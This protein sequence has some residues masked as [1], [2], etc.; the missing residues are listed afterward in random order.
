MSYD[1]RDHYYKEAK[2]KGFRAR[3]AFK[4]EQ[5]Q[6]K[7]YII[8]RKDIVIDLGA[9]PGGWTQ[10]ASK[11]VGKQGKVIAVDINHIK[12]FEND[13][14]YTLQVDMMS[15]QFQNLLKEIIEPPIDVVI[16]DLAGNTSGN[17]DLDSERQ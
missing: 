14:I 4:L 15:K 16:S 5:I 3:S 10:V 7:F 1:K 9:A 12:P 6:K 11:I 13:N 17:W 2:Q 8:K